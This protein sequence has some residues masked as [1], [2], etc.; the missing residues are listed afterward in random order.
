MP[1]VF[2]SFWFR[3]NFFPEMPGN[4]YPTAFPTLWSVLRGTEEENET[5]FD[6]QDAVIHL[7]KQVKMTH[8]LDHTQA[9]RN[10]M[11]L[12]KLRT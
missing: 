10:H 7:E 1:A 6:T 8:P 9:S 5:V 3:K 2:S 11:E 4:V 12:N